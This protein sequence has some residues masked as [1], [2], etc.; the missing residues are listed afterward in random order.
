M[1]RGG[2]NHYILEDRLNIPENDGSRYQL[3][4]TRLI[5]SHSKLHIDQLL[6]GPV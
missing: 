4:R 6:L 2:T 1:G 5:E 3:P